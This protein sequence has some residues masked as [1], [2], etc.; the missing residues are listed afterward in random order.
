MLFLLQN[1]GAHDIHTAA[2]LIHEQYLSNAEPFYRGGKNHIYFDGWKGL[3]ASAVLAAIAESAR[4]AGSKFDIVI[5]VDCSVWESRREMQR[6]IAKVLNL[7]RSGMALFDKQDEDDDF[8]GVHKSS[9]AEILDVA[10]LIFRFIGDRRCLMILH[11]GS[12]DEVDLS[13]SGVPVSDWR[14]KVLWTFQGRFRLDH[15]TTDKVKSAQV[16]LSALQELPPRYFKLKSWYSNHFELLRQEASQVTH[17]ATPTVIMDCWFFLLVMNYEHGNFI[18]HDQDSHASNYWVCDGIIRGN[19]AWETAERLQGAMR[20]NYMATKQD[21]GEWVDDALRSCSYRESR[22]SSRWNSS[23]GAEIQNRQSIPK[24]TTSY[25]LTLEKSDHPAALPKQLFEQS[26]NLRVL[27]LSW[28][29]FSFASPPFNWCNNLRFI[30]IDS[31]SDEHV[32]LIGKGDDKKDTEWSFLQSLWVLDI[33]RTRWDWILTPSKMVLMIELRELNLIDAGASWFDWGMAKL[34][35][36]WLCDLRRLRIINSSSFLRAIVVD[37]FM[38]M[39]NLELLDLSGNITM[40]DLP[41]LSA[42]GGL[43]VLILDG[44]KG[45]KNVEPDSISTSLESFSFDGFGRAFRWKHSLHILEK[46]VRHTSPHNHYPPKVSKISLEGCV[47]LKNVYLRGLPNLEELNLSETAIEALD[48]KAMSVKNLERLFLLGCEKLRRVQWLDEEYPVLKFLFVD[49]RGNLERSMDGDYQQSHSHSQLQDFAHIVAT[50]ARFLGG[51]DAFTSNFHLIFKK[52]TMTS[53]QFTGAKKTW[54]NSGS[55]DELDLVPVVRSSCPYLDVVD[56]VAQLNND[57][58]RL[59]QACTQ[60]L[61]SERHIE[62]AKGDCNLEAKGGH[63][64]VLWSLMNYAQSL[65]VHDNCSITTANLEYKEDTQFTNLRWCRIET[66]PNLHSVFLVEC[67]SRR[68]FMSLETFWASHLLGARC[69]W[70]RNLRFGNGFYIPP[71][72]RTRKFVTSHRLLNIG[73][74]PF[75]Q[76]RHIHL[77]SCP[78]L[79]FVLPWGF[80]SLNSL[81]TIHITYCGELRRIFPK[82]INYSQEPCT[83]IQYPNLRII[84]LQELPMLQYICE[85]NMSAPML[86]TIKLRGCWSLRRLPAIQVGRPRYKQPAVVDCEKDWWDKLQWDGLEASRRLFSPRHSR[87]HKKT[88]PR[89][90]LLRCGRCLY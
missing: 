43:K 59:K 18:D 17:D 69:I 32:E 58:D 33:R 88:I 19:S 10:D 76:L 77:H 6:R 9:R 66:C 51:F 4:C 7:G 84:H 87:Y 12:D 8:S 44:C 61:P 53:R 70:S 23:K 72:M 56:K 89:G 16:F 39:H 60:L 75:S 1:V 78:R 22:S 79:S 67:M 46:E 5:H 68:S 50:D 20:V 26:S 40:E 15:T 83:S 3:G 38:D 2:S 82:G 37:S 63:E 74:T 21:H 49:T 30:F 71:W 80:P 81:Q 62:I 65:H 42:A 90:S 27:R 36:K 41:N 24:E 54:E 31:C 45:L 85:I 28:C 86:E 48:L 64:T 29:S 13:A 11:N 14:T 55:S 25:F 52:S 73:A 34:E 47:R 57:E 35:M